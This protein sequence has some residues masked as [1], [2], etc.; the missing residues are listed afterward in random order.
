MD[1]MHEN[2]RQLKKKKMID[3]NN[4]VKEIF[5]LKCSWICNLTSYSINYIL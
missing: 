4:Q 1:I 5:G 3:L 2:I